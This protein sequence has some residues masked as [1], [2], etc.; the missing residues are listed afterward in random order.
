MEATAV[1]YFSPSD[2]FFGSYKTP[3]LSYKGGRAPQLSSW[4]TLK[5][6]VISTYVCNLFLMSFRYETNLFSDN[7]SH[8]GDV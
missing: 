7:G 4:R 3:K 6:S 5:W 2:D 8:F 1:S